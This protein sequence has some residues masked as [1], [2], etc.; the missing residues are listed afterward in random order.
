MPILSH[1]IKGTY[2]QHYITINVDLELLIEEVFV[3]VLHHEISLFSYF[4]YCPLRKEV[5]MCS[6]HLKEWGV[7]A[8]LP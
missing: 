4:P 5:T 7:Y 8:P 6:L 2:C 3:R 1:H